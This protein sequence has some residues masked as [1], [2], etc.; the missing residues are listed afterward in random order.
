MSRICCF[1][2]HRSVSSLPFKEIEL[3]LRK[4]L[5][6]LIENE[7]F[8]E[9]RAGGATGFDTIAALTVLKLKKQYPHIKLHLI[10]PCKCQDKYF[11]NIEKSLYQYTINHAD[12]VTYIQNHYTKDALF[13]RNRALVDGADLCVACLERLEGGTYYTVSYARKQRVKAINIMRIQ[14]Q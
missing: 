11:T 9:F 7:D 10:L 5:T 6:E 4:Y 13:A 2:G 3:R 8:T 12:S 1:T 14:R